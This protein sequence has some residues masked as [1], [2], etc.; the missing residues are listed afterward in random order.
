MKKELKHLKTFE[1]N[2]DK[3]LNI[4]DV[5]SSDNTQI[6]FRKHAENFLKDYFSGSDY[7]NQEDIINCMADFANTMITLSKIKELGLDDRI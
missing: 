1:Q 5:R 6:D 2:T 4:S 3:N 7:S